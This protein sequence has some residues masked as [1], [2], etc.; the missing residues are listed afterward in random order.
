MTGRVT[1]T[2]RRHPATL[3]VLAALVE[4]VDP[5][6]LGIRSDRG[7][8]TVDWDRL[9]SGGYLPTGEAAVSLIAQGLAVLEATGGRV[10]PRLTGPLRDAIKA[11]TR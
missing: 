5:D 8:T 6:T 9:A 2:P 11:V 1:L 4:G 10:P 7:G 3:A